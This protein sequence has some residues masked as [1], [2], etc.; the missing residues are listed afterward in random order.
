[1]TVSQNGII[2]EIAERFRQMH[3]MPCKAEFEVSG[4]SNLTVRKVVKAASDVQLAALEE[5]QKDSFL[6]FVL[7]IAS[8]EQFTRQTRSSSH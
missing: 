6:A 3:F 2:H 8:C 5:Q 7:S 4:S 1:M